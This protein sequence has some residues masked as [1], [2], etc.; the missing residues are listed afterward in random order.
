MERQAN[1]HRREPDFG[2]GDF[3]WVTTKNRRTE[4]PSCKLDYQMAGLYEILEKIGNAYKV[5]LPESIKVHLVF[6]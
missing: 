2:V 3:V 5:K 1:K 6:Y 4:R